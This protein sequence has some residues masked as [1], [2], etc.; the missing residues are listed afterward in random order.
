MPAAVPRQTEGY[1]MTRGDGVPMR[2]RP[3][4]NGDIIALLP[5]TGVV[6]VYTQFISDDAAWHVAYSNGALGF[7]RQDQLRMMS[8]EEAA[9]Y[10]KYLSSTT[11]APTPAPTPVPTPEPT[12][13]PEI[14]GS[15]KELGLEYRV[16]K[17]GTA[18][19]TKYTGKATVVDIPH[20]L[21]GH[22]VTSI[23]NSAFSTCTGLT[24]V[25]IPDSVISIGYYA[26]STCT[27]LT[28]VSIPDSVISI[29]YYAFY[30]CKSLT[31]VIL[32]NSVTSIGSAVFYSCKNLTSII[33][34]DSI[35][36]IGK[37]AFYNCP[38][39]TAQVTK[40]SYAEQY[41]KDNKINYQYQ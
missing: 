6:Y 2:L 34:P 14:S 12:A 36:S 37:S 32:P 29:G 19:I 39:L 33:L 40:G 16:K 22:R 21:D 1:A 18:E 7:I 4:D 13:V 11:P 25:S 28:S 17:D 8:E 5:Y 3:D 10:K 38:S 35:T 27:G 41:C 20:W 23:G 24:S 15:A 26:F 31:S 30:S 9:D